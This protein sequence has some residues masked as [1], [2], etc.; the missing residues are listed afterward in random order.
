[1][2]NDGFEIGIKDFLSFFDLLFEEHGPLNFFGEGLF[3]RLKFS[4]DKRMA[5]GSPYKHI[6][7]GSSRLFFY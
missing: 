7:N 5:I 1:M 2:K 3:K 6:F 4:F